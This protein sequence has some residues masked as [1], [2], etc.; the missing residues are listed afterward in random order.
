MA[1][2]AL[3]CPVVSDT[4]RLTNTGW[5]FDRRDLVERF[6]LEKLIFV[7][8]LVAQARGLCQVP[9]EAFKTVG[10]PVQASL[11]SPAA[12]VGAGTGL[13]IARIDSFKEGR[14]ASSEGGHIGFSPSDDVEMELLRFWR[15]H[16]GRVTNEHVISGPGLV[17]LYRALGAVTDTHVGPI[18]GPEIVR[19]AVDG[20]DALC[21]E[22]AERFAKILGS[23]TG[24][25]C[26]AFCASAAV[27]V[28]AIANALT[29][30]IARGGFR[31]RFEQRGPGG[32]FLKSVPTV[33]ASE[34]DLG[35]LGAY[36][37]LTEH[38]RRVESAT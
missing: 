4:P 38:S 30:I 29:P 20:S 16:L 19:H 8:D 33:I 35:M 36:A 5:K 24:D 11:L 10:P 34:P 26:L 2:L 13:G 25:I 1:A 17:R 9:A 3:A 22:T 14:I 7:N 27:L 21:V 18:D 31:S 12:V 28:G 15:R 23:V 32:A 37:F 6:Q